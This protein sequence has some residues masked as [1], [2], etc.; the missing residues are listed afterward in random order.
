MV[1]IPEPRGPPVNTDK[2][3]KKQAKN[4]LPHVSVRAQELCES[5][6]GR[7]GFPV[8]SSPYGVC[9]RKAPCK[10]KKKEERKK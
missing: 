10:K 7:P 1:S 3:T 4:K 5:R 2:K 8:S 6:G 9:G